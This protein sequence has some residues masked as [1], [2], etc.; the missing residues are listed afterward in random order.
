MVMVFWT[1]LELIRIIEPVE[2]AAPMALKVTVSFDKPEMD[3]I[4]IGG[5]MTRALTLAPV[6]AFLTE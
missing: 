2:V 6:A 4:L 3:R 1:L 5:L